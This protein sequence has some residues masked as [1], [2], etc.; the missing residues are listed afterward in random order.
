M[1]GWSKDDTDG[2]QWR[3]EP[4]DKKECETQLS[5]G[6]KEV[7]SQEHMPDVITR[8][9]FSTQ[10]VSQADTLFSSHSH[11]TANNSSTHLTTTASTHIPVSIAMETNMS[12]SQLALEHCIAGGVTPNPNHAA[13][14]SRH[15]PKVL[16]QL[17]NRCSILTWSPT[18][19]AQ[20]Q[21][22]STATEVADNSAYRQANVSEESYLGVVLTD[23]ASHTG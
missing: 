4:I 20:A 1:H 9:D 6:D 19:L 21:T 3:R 18:N 7:T 12:Q 5:V 22:S 11:D 8:P 16:T 13:S 15:Q 14:S 23:L 2:K 17:E 10:I